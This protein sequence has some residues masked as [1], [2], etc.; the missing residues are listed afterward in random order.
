MA[1]LARAL[2]VEL[3]NAE[4]LRNWHRDLTRN[5][6]AIDLTMRGLAL[7]NQPI[8][9]GQSRYEARD[10]FEQALTVDPTNLLDAL[11]KASAFVDQD[12]DYIYG[13]VRPECGPVHG[14]SSG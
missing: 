8:T 3:V 13:L 2:Q 1:R 9:G 7:L 12:A 10:L 6:D 5:P 14:R 11:A 4:A